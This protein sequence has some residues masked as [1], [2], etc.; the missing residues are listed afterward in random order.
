MTNLKV[1][2]SGEHLQKIRN[3]LNLKQKFTEPAKTSLRCSQP[4][5][6]KSVPRLDA[7]PSGTKNKTNLEKLVTIF[8]LVFNRAS[9]PGYPIE[10]YANL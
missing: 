4:P 10:R 3:G 2:K 1:T 6:H 7:G 8:V 9:F 5:G